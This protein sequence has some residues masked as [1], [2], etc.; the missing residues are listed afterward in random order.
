M[1]TAAKSLLQEGLTYEE[2]DERL[3]VVEVQELEPPA[4]PS[5]TALVPADSVRMIIQPY[6]DERDRV[7][8]ERDEALA[9]IAELE[10]ENGMLQGRLEAGARP[11]WR[12]ILG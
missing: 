5:S 2:A 1:L 8:A 6:I 11:W 12:R 9:R 3:A 4:D 10:R 7:L